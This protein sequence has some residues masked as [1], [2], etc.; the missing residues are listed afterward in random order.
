MGLKFRYADGPVLTV[1]DTTFPSTLR[2][3]RDHLT[4]RPVMVGIVGAGLILGISGPFETLGAIPAMPRVLYWLWVVAVSYGIGT[5][6]SMTAH[7]WFSSSL[8]A[9]L[10]SVVS[11]G[12]AVALILVLMNRVLFGPIYGSWAHLLEMFGMVTLISAI[13][14]VS[15]ALLRSGNK[16]PVGRPPLLKRLPFE[17]RGDL[18]SLSA[19][20]HY[21]RVVSTKGAE[22][23]L[24]RLSDA[25]GEV[26]DTPGL[27]VHR[28]H[29]V[30][31]Q[32]VSSVERNG[33]RGKVTLNNG[34]VIPISRSFLP[35][36]RKA[37][38]LPVAKGALK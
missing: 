34:E 6:F 35:D 12:L 8:L 3:A 17:K 37:G 20:D 18:V 31:L 10:V 22:L 30:A 9:L 27:Q 16:E 4:R 14:E 33:D 11:I 32:Q 5:V 28:S 1:N 23:V 25:M 36:V 7:R 21:V 19:E 24:M 26:G 2:E 38:L 15:G 29:W 13:V